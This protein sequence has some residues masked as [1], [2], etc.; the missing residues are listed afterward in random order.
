[1]AETKMVEK[2][3]IA[4]RQQAARWSITAQS[5]IPNAQVFRD[6]KLAFSGPIAN[7][8]AMISEAVGRAAIEAMRSPPDDV[9]MACQDANA[10]WSEDRD[11]DDWRQIWNAQI[12]AI[13]KEGD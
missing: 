4:A 12:D 8:H 9:V 5:G 7:C 6:G 1:M 2:V 10:Y 11:A 13:L 3:G